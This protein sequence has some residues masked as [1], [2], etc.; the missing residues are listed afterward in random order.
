MQAA[1]RP[2]Q[3]PPPPPGL[4]PGPAPTFSV[5]VPVYQGAG[6]VG[7]A[8]E[9]AL[10]QTT[11]P[12]EIVV[13]DDGSTD[14]LDAALEPYLDRIALLRQRNQG[15]A[16]A[17]NTALRH[18]SGDFVAVLDADDAYLPGR[19]EALAELGRE[20]PDLDLLAADA[21]F[22]RDGEVVGRVYGDTPFPVA[23]QRREII[24]RCFL[25]HPA[26]RRTRVLEI[27]GFDPSLRIAYDWDCWL[28]LILTG[29]GV[30]LVP[31]PL[32]RYRMVSGSLSDDRP[33]SLRERV[34]VLEKAA[35]QQA[36]GPDERR[37]LADR[38]A[39][40]RHR[41]LLAEARDAIRMRTPD[42]RRKALAVVLGP[43]M[44]PATR[45]KAA[46]AAVSPRLAHPVLVRRGEGEKER[47][48][49]SRR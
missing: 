19:L 47:F 15:A 49:G 1:N 14:G 28:R 25:F 9:S 22:E 45:A 5:L 33:R 11:P 39:A 43:R 17:L 34:T 18:A 38:L 31:E 2:V 42:A 3:A 24:D 4:R 23:D 16:A 37:F 44:S 13:C 8:I 46:L 6:T 26:A 48:P 35:D 21:Y 7:G 12:L 40:A 36:V 27:G 29:S 20:R 32:T 10:R 41:A 30:G